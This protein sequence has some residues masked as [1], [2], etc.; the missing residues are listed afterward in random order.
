MQQFAIVLMLFMLAIFGLGGL[1]VYI[2]NRR[3][4]EPFDLLDD[5]E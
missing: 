1:L 5:L 3:D 2:V 4:E